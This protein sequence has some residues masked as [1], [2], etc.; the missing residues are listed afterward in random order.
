[1]SFKKIVIL[2]S[3]FGVLGFAA[4]EAKAQAWQFHNPTS[5]NND[6]GP[7]GVVAPYPPDPQ[8][9]LLFAKLYAAIREG[10]YGEALFLWSE[11]LARS[12]EL[13]RERARD[14]QSAR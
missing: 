5:G 8:M 12:L 11:I 14:Q 9:M 7:D 4:P 6:F 1:M 10:S 2:V 13:E 3:L